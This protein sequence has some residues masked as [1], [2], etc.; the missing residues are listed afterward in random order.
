MKQWAYYDELKNELKPAGLKGN[1]L[2]GWY[3]VLEHLADVQGHRCLISGDSSSMHCRWAAACD[4][5][6]FLPARVHEK[7][8]KHLVSIR[9]F[10]YSDKMRIGDIPSRSTLFPPRLL[11]G[12]A[13]V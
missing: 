7:H 9:V 10:T 2:Q 4:A 8:T 6:R 1:I 11:E 5:F 13:E 3:T 12:F